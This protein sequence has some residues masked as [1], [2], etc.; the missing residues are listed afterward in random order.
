MIPISVVAA[1]LLALLLAVQDAPPV[2][3]PEGFVVE[4]IAASPLVERPIMAC[5]DEQGR[6]YNAGMRKLIGNVPIDL[7][8]VEALGALRMAGKSVHHLQERWAEMHGLGH[9]VE[10]VHA[11]RAVLQDVH[12]AWG[13]LERRTRA[14]SALPLSETE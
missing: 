10:H 11:Q 4:K 2:Q 8:A 1:T 14:P 9:G 6:L 7:G 13:Y 12:R 5:F 3:V